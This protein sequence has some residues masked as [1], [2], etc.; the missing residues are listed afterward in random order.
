MPWGSPSSTC[1]SGCIS[2]TATW[3]PNVPL[4]VAEAVARALPTAQLT[5][6]PGDGHL[7]LTRHL[8][9][10][11]GDLTRQPAAAER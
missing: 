2:G 8:E 10:I 3:T 4:P 5:V 11:L 1:A 7:S 6:V 9:A